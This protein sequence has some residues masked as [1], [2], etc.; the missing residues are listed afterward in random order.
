MKRIP[1]NDEEDEPDEDES[2]DLFSDSMTQS[3]KLD[4]F[5]DYLETDEWIFPV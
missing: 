3:Q 1:I 2:I 5:M 4:L